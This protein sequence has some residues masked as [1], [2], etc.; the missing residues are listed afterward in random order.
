MGD[1]CF[2]SPAKFSVD[3]LKSRASAVNVVPISASC[4]EVI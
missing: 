2:K 4:A 1:V 3:S